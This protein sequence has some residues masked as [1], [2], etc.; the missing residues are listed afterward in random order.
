MGLSVRTVEKHLAKALQRCQESVQG[1][2][3]AHADV[4]HREGKKTSTARR[5]DE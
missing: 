1:T 5:R 3:G 4:E 2:E